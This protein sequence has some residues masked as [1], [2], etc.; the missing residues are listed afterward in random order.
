[1]RSAAL[2][3]FYTSP[4]NRHSRHFLTL[5][6]FQVAPRPWSVLL[7]PSPFNS[8]HPLVTHSSSSPTPLTTL[9]PELILPTLPPIR[10]PYA[11]W[12]PCSVSCP[13]FTLATSSSATAPPIRRYI[14]LIIP[15]KY[16]TTTACVQTEYGK[17]ISMNKLITLYSFLLLLPSARALFFC[18]FSL[19]LI[20]NVQKVERNGNEHPHTIPQIHQ[21]LASLG[22]CFPLKHI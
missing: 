1:M 15:T 10:C 2:H 22:C 5:A 18:A 8:T 11:F 16:R 9:L 13:S 7:S 21:L 6:S 19:F 12:S 4:G 17:G 14:L 20:S 3:M